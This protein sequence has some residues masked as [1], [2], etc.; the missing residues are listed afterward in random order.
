MKHIFIDNLCAQFKGVEDSTVKLDKVKIRRL[1][2]DFVKM[3][4]HRALSEKEE[5]LNKGMIKQAAL[6]T[7]FLI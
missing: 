6:D 3:F 2:K 1:T 7:D 5:Q 4:G